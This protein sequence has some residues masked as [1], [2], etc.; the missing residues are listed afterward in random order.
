MGLKKKEQER[1]KAGQSV[2]GGRAPSDFVCFIFLAISLVVLWLSDAHQASYTPLWQPHWHGGG[3]ARARA[4]V[5]RS[6]ARSRAGLDLGPQ[7]SRVSPPSFITT[8]HPCAGVAGS[9]PPAFALRLLQLAWRPV[10]PSSAHSP[11]WNGHGQSSQG[12]GPAGAELCPGSDCHLQEKGV[13]MTCGVL[14]FRQGCFG[15]GVRR[16]SGDHSTE[17]PLQF[18]SQPCPSPFC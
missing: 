11:S 7:G 16:G 13:M 1:R 15:R 10:P 14:G 4:R 3:G 12:L 2:S 18:P 8:C 6:P 5:Q 9:R 17:D